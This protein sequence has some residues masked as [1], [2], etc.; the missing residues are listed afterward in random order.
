[1]YNDN[2]I[3]STK[4]I[5]TYMQHLFDLTTHM[6]I[7]GQSRVRDWPSIYFLPP[8]EMSL[9]LEQTFKVSKLYVS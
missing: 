3:S 9:I 2:E 4:C 8:V 5:F 7:A 1:M 6:S